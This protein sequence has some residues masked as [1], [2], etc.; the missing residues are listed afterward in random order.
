MSRAPVVAAYA[1]AK[2]TDGDAT[3]FLEKWRSDGPLDVSPG[4]LASLGRRSQGATRIDRDQAVYIAT[5]FLKENGYGV[6]RR[7]AELP[8]QDEPRLCEFDACHLVDVGRPH[9]SVLFTSQLPPEVESMHPEGPI[10][11]VDA[12][13]G[14]AGFFAAL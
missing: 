10:V 7:V 5:A 6:V 2:H 8:W 13:T 12:D 3:L 14:R 4:L 1:L 11:Q 9:W